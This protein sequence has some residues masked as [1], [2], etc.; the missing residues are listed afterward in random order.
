LL[1]TLTPT[2][3]RMTQWRALFTGHLQHNVKLLVVYLPVTEF[4]QLHTALS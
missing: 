1:A 2:A 3:L 4:G